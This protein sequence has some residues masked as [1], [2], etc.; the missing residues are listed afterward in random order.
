ML[1]QAGFRKRFKWFNT[2]FRFSERI[3]KRVSFGY[4]VEDFLNNEELL[5]F[6]SP[7]SLKEEKRNGSDSLKFKILSDSVDHKTDSWTTKNLVSEWIGEF[8]KLAAAK[9]GNDLSYKSLKIREDEFV[10]IVKT[11]E[12]KFDSLWS[13]GIFT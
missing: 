4:P 7:E 12:N 6:Y 10:K 11:N 8:S 9:T 1:R 3:D 13:N 2:E 5:Y